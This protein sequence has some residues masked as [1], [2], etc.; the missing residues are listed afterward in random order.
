[1]MDRPDSLVIVDPSLRDF[2]GHHYEYDRA[3]VIAARDRGLSPV[4][5]GHAEM[6]DG[7]GAAL[8]VRKAFT[9][10]I[11]QPYPAESGQTA[12]ERA[13]LAANRIFRQE[14]EAGLAQTPDAGNRLLFAHMITHRQLF[15]LAEFAQR[16]LAAGRLGLCLLL[17]YQASFYEHPLC[18]RAFRIFEEL[19]GKGTIR[20]VSDSARLSAQIQRLTSLPV[21]VVPIPHTVSIEGHRPTT[22]GARARGRLRV[23]SLGNA[24]DEKGLLE[25]FQAVRILEAAGQASRFEFHLQVNNPDAVTAPA[26]EAFADEGH[27]NA[28]LYREALDT[29]D[30]YALLQSADIVAVPYWREIYEARTSGVFLEAVAASKPVIC[31]GDTWMADQ[32]RFCGAGLLCRNREPADFVRQLCR[33]ADDYEGHAR[34]ALDGQAAW[35]ERHNPAST[36]AVVLGEREVDLGGGHSRAAVLYPWGDALER[37]AGASVRSNQLAQFLA[38]RFDE[39]RFLENAAHGREIRRG[40]PFEAYHVDEFMKRD[41]RLRFVGWCCRSILGARDREELFLLMHLAAELDKR[42][43]RRLLEIARWSDAVFL[44]Y[45]FWGR[46]AAQACKTANVPLVLTAHDVL[47]DQIRHSRI[48]RALTRWVENR[49]LRAAAKRVSVSA[50]DHDRFAARGLPT[51]VIPHP[52]DVRSLQRRLPFSTWDLMLRLCGLPLDT[53]HVFL[54]VGSRYEPNVVAAGKVFELAATFAA[55]HPEEKARFVVA[56]ACRDPERTGIVTSMGK[57]SDMLLRLLYENARGVVIP[58]GF[59]TGTSLKTVEAMACGRAVI[60][61]SVAFRGLPVTHGRDCLVEDDLSNWTTLL[62]LLCR[63]DTIREQME[64]GAAETAGAY[65]FRNLFKPYLDLTGATKGR[66]YPA[67]DEDADPAYV[68]HLRSVVSAAFEQGLSEICDAAVEALLAVVPNDAEAMT[69]RAKLLMRSP[70]CGDDA[71]EAAIA[72]ALAAGGHVLEL[73][74]DRADWRRLR[75]DSAGANADDRLLVQYAVSESWTPAGSVALRERLWKAF[76]AGDRTWVPAVCEEIIRLGPSQTHADYRYLLAHCLQDR[77]TD[78]ERCLRLYQAA[79]EDGFQPFWPHYHRSGLL[80]SMGDVAGARKEMALAVASA[81]NAEQRAQV[82]RTAEDEAWRLHHAGRHQAALEGARAL[83]DLKPDSAT[84]HYLIA[85]NLRETG[86]PTA[87]V[88]RHLAQAQALGYARCWIVLSQGWLLRREGDESGALAAFAEARGVSESDWLTDYVNGEIERPLWKALQGGDT[89]QAFAMATKVLAAL[90]DNP[91]ARY[92][93]AASALSQSALPE[94]R[95][96]AG[97]PEIPR[98]GVPAVSPDPIRMPEATPAELCSRLASADA[99]ERPGLRETL[100]KHLWAAFDRSEFANVRDL[101]AAAAAADDTFAHAHYLLAE[102]VQILNGD[103]GEAIRHYDA[104]LANGFDRYW[105]LF[106]RAQAKRK[107]NLFDEAARDLSEL[108]STEL[109][110]RQRQDVVAA[111]RDL[112]PEFRGFPPIHLRQVLSAA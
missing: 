65:D 2:V 106:N 33:L 53:E 49:G 16:R 87:E 9:R 34:K 101:A 67:S 35:L 50:G 38:E 14:M 27:A 60:G 83:L 15:G 48:I 17:R 45:S 108:L 47:S 109:T 75:A 98:N 26:I 72:S 54:F 7:I 8:P 82:V 110:A 103:P 28:V 91:D 70:D 94:I 86:A 100:Q 24:R 4:V 59:G 5:L 57:V 90:P 105:C 111:A 46:A 43:H 61:T 36:L 63:D 93:L 62:A 29:D 6:A 19:A 64:K 102:C 1:M 20:I 22:A 31:T 107:A 18:E 41:W 92:V 81:E 84:A 85:E 44:E 69:V 25:I 56:G 79:L 13:L 89:E 58:L 30:Y 23:V 40:L 76:H 11:W 112:E 55:R 37:T 42:F 3:V 66:E 52:M 21:G 68:A 95:A 96:L 104:A 74:S 88:R 39:V 99:T 10:D 73:L 97:S 32:L 77:G 80:A 71:I 78:P 51:T 12:P